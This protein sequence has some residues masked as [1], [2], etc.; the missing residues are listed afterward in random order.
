MSFVIAVPEAL[1]SAASDMAGIGSVLSA[2]NAAAAGPTT[3]LLAAAEDEVSA[4]IAAVF[5]SHAQE[6]QALSA[7][8]AAFHQQFVQ[9]VTSGAR[10]YASAEATNAEQQLLG[11]I[12]APAQTLLVKSPIT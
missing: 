4:A 1:L 7:R 10:L 11:M 6:Y 2:A 5:G 3:A 12:N 9:A 8:A